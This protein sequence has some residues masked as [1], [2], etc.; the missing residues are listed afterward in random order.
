MNPMGQSDLQQLVLAMVPATVL[1]LKV[2]VNIVASMKVKVR[3]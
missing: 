3:E 2:K 1:V